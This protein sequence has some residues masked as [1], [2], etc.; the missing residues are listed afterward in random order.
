MRLEDH[1]KLNP[2]SHLRAYVEVET[3]VVGAAFG[4]AAASLSR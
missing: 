1:Q 3:G 4:W 2:I